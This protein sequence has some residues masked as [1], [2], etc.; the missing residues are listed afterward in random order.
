[1]SPLRLNG[2][3]SGF[4]TLEAPASAGSNTL[5]LPTGNGSSGQ[6][7]STN[8][9][10]ALS[11]AAPGKILQV[12][13]AGPF[14]GVTTSSG[15]YQ[16]S[17]TIASITPLF[18]SSKILQLWSTSIQIDV[19]NDS[20]GVNNGLVQFD[21][22]IGGTG[23]AWSGLGNFNVPGRGGNGTFTN[24]VFLSSF[25]TTSTVYFRIGVA[26]Y[27]GSRVIIINDSWGSNAVF[28]ME[29]AA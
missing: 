29:V 11:W 25:S 13:K 23:G 24:A 16:Y 26:K 15:S 21:Y 20:Q 5:V 12:V 28:L 10:G 9:S 18:A 3:S 17:S 4:V 22:Q 2:S 1:M 14:N 8:G 19:D 7:L 27:E 6:V